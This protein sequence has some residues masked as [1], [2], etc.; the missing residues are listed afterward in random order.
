MYTNINNYYIYFLGS[1]SL[2]GT[3]FGV[4]SSFSLAYYSIQIKKVLPYVNNQ[5]WLLSYF[6]NVYATILF[7]PLLTLEAKE[8]TNYRELAEFK[9]LLLMIIGG[10]CGLLIGYVTVLQVQ[11]SSS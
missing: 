4:F 3:A 5:I 1:F 8:L 6:N 2:V 7:I 11:V 9:F 10:V